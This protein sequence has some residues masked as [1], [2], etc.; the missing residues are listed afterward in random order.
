MTTADKVLAPPTE[1][2][3]ILGWLKRNLFGSIP[4]S[5]LTILALWLTYAM[6]APTMTWIF[7]EASWAVIPDNLKLFMV[8]RYPIEY[9]WR[10][11]FVLYLLAALTASSGACGSKAE[12][13]PDM[14]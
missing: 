12:R 11:W 1:R 14:F 10:I 2:Y 8:G 5:I 13:S 9:V 4:D 7:G 6:L 3:T